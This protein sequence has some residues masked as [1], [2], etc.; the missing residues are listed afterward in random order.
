MEAKEA[1]EEDVEAEVVV[2]GTVMEVIKVIIVEIMVDTTVAGIK[3][4]NLIF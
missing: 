3:K 1:S 4:P 2:E